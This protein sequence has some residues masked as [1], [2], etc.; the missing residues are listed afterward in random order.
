[1]LDLAASSLGCA[2]AG[3]AGLELLLLAFGFRTKALSKY[4]QGSKA[5]AGGQSGRGYCDSLTMFPKPTGLGSQ[6]CFFALPVIVVR[7]YCG[8]GSLGRADQFDGLRVD[9]WTFDTVAGKRFGD[10][11]NQFVHFGAPGTAK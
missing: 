3:V 8:S 5:A 11:L 9:G 10:E 6:H 7:K 1:V 2:Q 4:F